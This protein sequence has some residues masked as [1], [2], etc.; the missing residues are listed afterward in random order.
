[1]EAFKLFFKRLGILTAVLLIVLTCANATCKLV[2]FDA[3]VN[4]TA[5]AISFL[6]GSGE[7][8]TDGDV[9]DEKA[10]EAYELMTAPDKTTVPAQ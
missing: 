1:M 3:C 4:V 10:V 6:Q 7:V 5:T 8:K 9:K 2:G